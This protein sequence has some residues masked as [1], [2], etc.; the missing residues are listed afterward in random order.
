[1]QGILDNRFILVVIHLVDICF[2]IVS[3]GGRELSPSYVMGEV[4]HYF[5]I[6]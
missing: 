1:M 3:V 6:G 5:T 2:Y 4:A